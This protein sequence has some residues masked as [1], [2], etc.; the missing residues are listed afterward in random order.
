LGL[1]VSSG[2]PEVAGLFD[3]CEAADLFLAHDLGYLQSLTIFASLNQKTSIILYHIISICLLLLG[4][5]RLIIL[6]QGFMEVLIYLV[7][8]S[9]MAFTHHWG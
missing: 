7:L 9:G 3:R 2:K 8:F 4:L 5:V 1:K 6:S